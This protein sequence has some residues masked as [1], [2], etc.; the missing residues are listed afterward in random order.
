MPK[1]EPRSQDAKTPR[2]QKRT[3]K[4]RCQEAKEESNLNI[5]KPS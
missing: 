4:P 1:K 3:K 2:C 5:Q